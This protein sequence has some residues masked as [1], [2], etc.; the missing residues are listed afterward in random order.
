MLV[1]HLEKAPPEKQ[2]Y[3][4]KA[5]IKLSKQEKIKVE[6]VSLYV[7]QLR[8]RWYDDDETTA[9]AMEYLKNASDEQQTKIAGKILLNMNKIDKFLED[10]YN[11]EEENDFY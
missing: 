8:R 3:V 4:A 7:R 9:L 1:T 5:I 11:Q 6:P 2:V 10:F